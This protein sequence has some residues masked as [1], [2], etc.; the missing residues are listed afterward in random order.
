MPSHRY[1]DVSDGSWTTILR[2]CGLWSNSMCHVLLS[3]S[4]ATLPSQITQIKHGEQ[5]MMVSVL[6][7]VVDCAS[8]AVLAAGRGHSDVGT[9]VIFEPSLHTVI[10]VAGDACIHAWGL[11]PCLLASCK[12]QGLLVRLLRLACR[13]RCLNLACKPNFNPHRCQGSLLICLCT[14]NRAQ[15]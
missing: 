5:N 7:S 4:A 12:D 2:Y 9:G 3:P 13:F 1:L 8:G 6:C 15:I 11:P 10:S 14:L